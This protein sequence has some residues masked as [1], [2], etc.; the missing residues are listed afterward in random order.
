MIA[1][2]DDVLA[3]APE[4]ATVTDPQFAAAFRLVGPLIPEADL[5]ERAAIAGAYRIAHFLAKSRPELSP[6][7]KVVVSE[8]LGPLSRTYAVA[9][10]PAYLRD[11]SSTKYGLAYLDVIGGVLFTGIVG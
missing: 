1:T 8:T 2:K 9:L 10:P 5:G 6:D 11:L 3:V 4:F 7:S